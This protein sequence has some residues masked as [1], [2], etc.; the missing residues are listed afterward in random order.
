MHLVYHTLREKNHSRWQKITSAFSTAYR[1]TNW[2]GP[3][4]EV[5]GI[6]RNASWIQTQH[7]VLSYYDIYRIKLNGSFEQNQTENVNTVHE[8][9]SSS[10]C[11]CCSSS[12]SNCSYIYSTFIS[13]FFSYIR[14]W[15]RRRRRRFSS[16]SSMLY[17]YLFS[18]VL[19][20]SVFER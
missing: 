3:A 15:R 4:L 10:P 16:S 20:V 13:F 17:P 8:R 2:F 5:A 1:C 19:Y 7:C 18:L 9:C 11:F 12:S 6:W 14:R